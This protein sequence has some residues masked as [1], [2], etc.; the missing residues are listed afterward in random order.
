MT[1]RQRFLRACLGQP[2]DHPPIWL[3][4]QAGRV[5]PEYRSLKEKFTFL[6]LVQTPGL[7]AEVTLQPIRRFGFDAA[8]LFSDI[9]VVAE[10]MGQAYNFRDQGGIEMAFSIRSADD[11]DQLE[12]SAVVE[13]LQYVAEAIPLIKAELGNR[14]ALLGFAGSPWTLANFMLEGGSAKEFSKAKALFYSDPVLFS[15]LLE[16]LTLAVTQF[17]QLQ[18]EAGVDAIQIFDSLAGVLPAGTYAPASGRW[19]TKIIAALEQR[20][21]VIVFA[22]GANG[23][24]DVLSKTGANVL[25]VDWTVHLSDVRGWVPPPIGLQGNLDPFVLNT[26]PEIVAAEARRILL[27]MR[28]HDGFIFNLGHGTPPNAKLENLESLVTAVHSFR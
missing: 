8:I 25:S 22:K 2:V 19:I 3:M 24:F 9:L 15:R 7:A 4:R 17:L 10:A 1:G 26:T 12:P 16:K 14:T 18:I 5:L 20:A 23:S 21:P 28:G 11:I 13:R 6:E 27:E